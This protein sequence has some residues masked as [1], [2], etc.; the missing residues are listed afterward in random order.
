MIKSQLLAAN[1]QWND[2]LSAF[3]ETVD[4]PPLKEYPWF[5]ADT[6]RLWSDAHLARG[7]ADDQARAKQL[8]EKS[9]TI[10]ENIG[11][12]VYAERVEAQINDLA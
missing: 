10:F 7:E 1:Q 12:T 5:V 6:F 4:L 3:E 11:A 2:S 9:L 8:L